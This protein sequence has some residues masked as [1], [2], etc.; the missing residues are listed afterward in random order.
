M[1]IA[2]NEPAPQVEPEV[3]RYKKRVFALF[4]VALFIP[5]S[6][7]VGVRL[8][9][10][11]AYLIV[12]AVPILLQLRNDP[13][14]RINAVDILV[15]FS[16]SWRGVALVANHG[17]SELVNAGTFFLELFV[18]YLL[19]RAFIRSAADYR[20]FFT[21]FLGALVVVLPLALVELTMHRRL[22]RSIAGVL[23]TQPPESYGDQIRFGLM[24]VQLSFEHGLLFGTFCAIGFANVFYIWSHRFP[25][26]LAYSG[27]V[28]FMTALGLSSSSMLN[29]ALQGCLIVY[30]RVLRPVGSKWLILIVSLPLLWFLFQMIAGQNFVDF[31]ADHLVINPYVG[32]GR[33]EI[34]YWGMREAIAHPVFGIGKNDWVRPFWRES[35]TADNFW[36][37]SA[38]RYGFPHALS[39]MLAFVIQIVRVSLQGGLDAFEG[40]CR[41]GFCI[42]LA[43]LGVALFNHNLWGAVNVFVMLYLA[44][45][46][47]VYDRAQPVS[48]RRIPVPRPA[49][50]AVPRAASQAGP[51]TGPQAGAARPVRSASPMTGPVRGGRREGPQGGQ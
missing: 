21:C 7:D 1:A 44:S 20:Y 29:V 45:G 6:V 30:E 33:K 42:A 8:D 19:G 3:S 37:A 27:F 39:L 4:F 40:A 14:F 25:R 38:F 41:R 5:G 13:T 28:A 2:L 10:Y 36:V 46:A 18:G 9:V 26:N 48:R 49:P 32:E 50:Q 16:V 35:T 15:F 22:L 51:P 47:W 23:L 11:R 12:M 17:T 24:R 43:S 31:V 34:F